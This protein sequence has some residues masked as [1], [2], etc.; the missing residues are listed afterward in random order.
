MTPRRRNPPPKGLGSHPAPGALSRG[1]HALLGLLAKESGAE[2]LLERVFDMVVDLE[3]R[4]PPS[5]ARF[6]R[7]PHVVA[8]TRA[9]A[10]MPS[11]DVDVLC[12]FCGARWDVD[13]RC[14]ET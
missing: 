14:P 10:S 3:K 9:R 11:D 6:P 12:G 8:R 13:H 7:R 5:P 4:P 2:E 1:A